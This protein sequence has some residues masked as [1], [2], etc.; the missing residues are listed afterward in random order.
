MNTKLAT[1][2]LLTE[3]SLDNWCLIERHEEPGEHR[4]W[5]EQTGPGSLAFR[6]SS[7]LGD[8]DVEGY[9]DEMLAIADAIE[10]RSSVV[11]K[12]C[13]VDATGDVVRFCSPRNSTVDGTATLA[14]AQDLAEQIRAK[15]GGKP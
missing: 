11:F 12:R 4:E 5:M 14:A 8:A 15:F 2:L 6:V 13:S 10:R 3:G 1:R 7:R 9:P